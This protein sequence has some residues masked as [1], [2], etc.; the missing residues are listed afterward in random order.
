L[1]GVHIYPAIARHFARYVPEFC[2]LNPNVTVRLC[3]FLLVA[4]QSSV[5]KSQF[6]VLNPLQKKMFTV[7][8][9]P[10][11]WSNQHLYW[12]IPPFGWLNHNFRSSNA[13]L[14]VRETHQNIIFAQR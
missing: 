7:K 5:I 8:I 9:H 3:Q 4:C 10:A 2:Q 12:L 6:L 1:I 14:F 11:C 13:P